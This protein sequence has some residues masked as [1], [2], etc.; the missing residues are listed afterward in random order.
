MCLQESGNPSTRQPY[1]FTYLC[2][3]RVKDTPVYSFSYS[4]LKLLQ[5]VV[6][7][8]K[9]ITYDTLIELTRCAL[10]EENDFLSTTKNIETQ[11]TENSGVHTH[12]CHRDE[13]VLRTLNQVSVKSLEQMSWENSARDKVS[14]SIIAG[15]K[16]LSC[17]TKY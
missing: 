15:F 11:I 6:V 2:D 16:K 10:S 5:R 17:D 7:Y 13:F 8:S 14:S 3:G 9:S 12:V 1:Y 4:N